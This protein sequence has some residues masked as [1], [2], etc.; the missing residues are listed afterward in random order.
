MLAF[1][2]LST[3][4]ATLL[5]ALLG[6]TIGSIGTYY[7]QYR[8]QKSNKERRTEWVRQALL[9]ELETMDAL[10]DW[11]HDP[12]KNGVPHG[13]WLHNQVYE[14]ISGELGRLNEDELSALIAF[15]AG[16]RHVMSDIDYLSEIPEGGQ[17]KSISVI[18]NHL[19]HIKY[20]RKAAIHLISKNKNS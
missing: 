13:N 19:S 16:A 20:Q 18:Q 12:D 3:S 2:E 7:A 11:P 1:S 17:E 6:G 5:S 15:H 8:L 10:E 9:S 14:S 4:T